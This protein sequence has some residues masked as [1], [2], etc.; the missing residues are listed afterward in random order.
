M[1][2]LRALA[3]SLSRLPD[4][5][6]QFSRSTLGMSGMGNLLGSSQLSGMDAYNEIGAV[7]G[8]IRRICETISLVDWKLYE[9]TYAAGK[10]TRTEI[11]DATAPANHIATALWT[12]C[13]PIMTRRFFLYLSQLWQETT[14]G[15]YWLIVQGGKD[16]SPFPAKIKADI[17]LWPISPERITPIPDPD[18]YVSGYVYTMGMEKIPLPVEA[19]IP[20]GYP[21]PRNPLRFSGPLGAV[22]TDLEAE[23]YASQYNRNVFL[24]GAQ[25]GG[26]IEFDTPLPQNRFEEMVQRWREQHQGVN[27]AARVAIIEGGK[28]VETGQKNTDMEYEKLRL[29]TQKEVMFARAMPYAVMVT[30]D[31]NLANADVGM[32]LFYAGTIRP[33]LE[34]AKEAVNLRV[35]PYLGDNLTMD[36]ELPVPQDPALDVFASST[37]WLSGLCTQNQALEAQ[38][39]GAIG[40]DGDR[41]I[42]EIAGAMAPALPPPPKPP[43]RPTHLSYRAEQKRPDPTQGETQMTDQWAQQRL[44]A[45]RQQYLDL[46]ASRN[47]HN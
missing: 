23:Q 42:W 17:E 16:G 44:S 31:V 41:Y 47:G 25:P 28:W 1:T 8:P 26:V 3:G 29:L 14:G 32:K 21:D 2:I 43:R 24:N 27:N 7:Y 46:L 6:L 10:T 4:R 38:G 12:Q 36:F 37:N 33:P 30:Q 5:V 40:P 15:C 9:Q 35:L 39:Y 13:N 11:D 18:K 22:R 45:L 20:V 19:V 34:M